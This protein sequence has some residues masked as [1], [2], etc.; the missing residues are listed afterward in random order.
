MEKI[1]VVI[2]DDHS[3]IAQGI[4][5][6]LSHQELIEVVASF[7]SGEVFVSNLDESDPD[8]VLLDINLPG[9]NGM[10]VCSAVLN[11]KPDLGIIGL[12]NYSDSAFVKNMMRSGA[13][14]YLLKN[15]QKG[16][17]IAA[18]KSVYSGEVY[19]PENLKNQL[20]GDSIGK[21]IHTSFIPKLSRREKEILDLIAEELTSSEIAEKLFISLKT[22]ESHRKNLLQKLNARNSA[23]LIKN[24]IQKGLINI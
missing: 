15:T 22:V 23:G 7:K 5:K 13:K 14:G 1:R 18:I 24:A 3:M 4:E 21:S 17:L 11:K 6:M 12:S 2:V 20:L 9:M 8:V 19:L 16:E 10:E